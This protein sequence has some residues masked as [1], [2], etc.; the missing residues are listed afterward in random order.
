MHCAQDKCPLEENEVKPHLTSTGPTA[1]R[2]AANICGY[3]CSANKLE[4]SPF[5][6]IYLFTLPFI[7][8]QRGIQTHYLQLQIITAGGESRNNNMWTRAVSRYT[9]VA[10]GIPL[11]GLTRRPVGA[12]IQRTAG[13]RSTPPQQHDYSESSWRRPVCHWTAALAHPY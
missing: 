8:V 7:H 2:R 3:R 11:R 5:L 10:R 6:L 4:H 12:S 1:V 9:D 13:G